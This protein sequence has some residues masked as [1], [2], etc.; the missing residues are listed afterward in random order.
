MVVS[1]PG[2]CPRGDESGTGPEAQ[3]GLFV[4][5]AWKTLWNGRDKEVLTSR[6]VAV[7]DTIIAYRITFRV[8]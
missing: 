1:V 6:V 4:W 7:Y 2:S 3:G 8:G 5:V